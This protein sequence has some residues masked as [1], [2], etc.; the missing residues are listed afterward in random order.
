MVLRKL[1]GGIAEARKRAI[2]EREVPGPRI[3]TRPKMGATE[4]MDTGKWVNVQSSWC[5]RIKYI[6]EDRTLVVAYID[7]FV[8][9]YPAVGEGM[10]RQIF[11]ATS[12][13]K[14]ARRTLYGMPYVGY[15]D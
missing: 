4:W 8:A 12:I 15:K 10:A 13:G 9:A 6:K 7:G 14:F 5:F 2:Y 3:Q 11:W 1:I